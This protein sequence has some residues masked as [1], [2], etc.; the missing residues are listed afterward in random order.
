MKGK[1]SYLA[2][3]LL[4]L[5][6]LISLCLYFAIPTLNSERFTAAYSE[7]PIPWRADTEL[8]RVSQKKHHGSSAPDESYSNGRL[9]LPQYVMNRVKTFVFFLGYAHSGHSILGSL[10]D[11]PGIPTWLYHTKRIYLRSYQGESSLLPKQQYLMQYG[12]TLY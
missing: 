1:L 2:I 3:G 8:L 4:F 9:K 7:L 5:P 12:K 10:M 6:L 11:S